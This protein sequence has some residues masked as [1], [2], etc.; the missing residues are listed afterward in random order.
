VA[1]VTTLHT[2]PWRRVTY[3]IPVLELHVLPLTWGPQLVRL[4]SGHVPAQDT[5][6]NDAGLAG[7]KSLES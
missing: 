3:G 5:F 4:V 6:L 7:S 1:V 2:L